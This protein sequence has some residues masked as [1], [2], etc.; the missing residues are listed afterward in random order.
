MFKSII[1]AASLAGLLSGLLLT[2]VQQLQVA[3]LILAAERYEHAATQAPVGAHAGPAHVE[4]GGAWMGQIEPGRTLATAIANIVVATGFGLLLA[5][6]LSWRNESGWRAGLAWGVAGYVVF[7]VAPSIGLPPLL[8]GQ[9]AAPLIARELWWLFA[10]A[11]SAA[12]CAL[13]ML[14]R[15]AALRLLAIGVIA[16]PQLVGAPQPALHASA[17]PGDLARQ[18]VIA[19]FAANAVFWLALGAATGYL[20]RLRRRQRAMGD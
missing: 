16:A 17:I 2:A 7:F 4:A 9:D 5:S 15:K 14:Q 3:P 12:G 8:P 10:V 6:A 11:C 20:L 19:S 18:F 1:A 13:L